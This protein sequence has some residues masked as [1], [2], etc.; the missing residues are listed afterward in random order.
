MSRRHRADTGLNLDSLMDTLTNVV[1]FL[2]LLLVFMQL[3][4]GDAMERIRALTP[5][6]FELTE[7][8]VAALKDKAQEAAARKASLEARRRAEEEASAAAGQA[9]AGEQ[10]QADNKRAAP[11]VDIKVEDAQRLLDQLKKRLPELESR[12]AALDEELARLT[13][14]LDKTPLA[15]TPPGVYVS[16][17]DPHGAEPGFAPV[18]FF[19]KN[20]RIFCADLPALRKA[21]RERIER[22]M[23]SFEWRDPNAKRTLSPELG[24][25]DTRRN[26]SAAPA[27]ASVIYDG[28]KIAESFKS[29][30]LSARDL[31]VRVKTYDHSTRLNILIEPVAGKGEAKGQLATGH[32]LYGA[33]LFSL[34]A[35]K[36]KVYAQFLV[37]PDSFDLYLEARALADKYNVP[38]G[39]HILYD[40]AWEVSLNEPVEVVQRVKPPPPPANA[41]PPKPQP[42]PKLLD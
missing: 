14:L 7:A 5:E 8:D 25:K 19:C 28:K 21:V 35:R 18:Y 13:A 29:R 39:W 11:Q 27:K 30:P 4:V 20:N 17:P 10:A 40:A 6:A 22:S 1:G 32:S 9:L 2:V 33:T 36:E 42:P 12:F 16:L 3:G 26:K 24:L 31:Q 37:Y 15:Q 23:A 34:S 38:A 41:A